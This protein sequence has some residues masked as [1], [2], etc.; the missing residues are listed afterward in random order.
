MYKPWKRGPR[1][2]KHCAMSCTKRLK[3]IGLRGSPCGRPICVKKECVR[4]FPDRI[5]KA[6]CLNI[7]SNNAQILK[8]IP[9]DWSFIKRRSLWIVSKHLVKSIKQMK[10]RFFVNSLLFII[11]QRSVAAL[12]HERPLRKPNCKVG[13]NLFSS[14]S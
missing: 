10:V 11:S 1:W 2:G 14:A 4:Y 5:T 6:R 8:G 3:R 7:K 9:I 12:V 13:S